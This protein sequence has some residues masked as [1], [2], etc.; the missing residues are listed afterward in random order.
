MNEMSMKS[1]N[2]KNLLQQFEP[3]VITSLEQSPAL[4]VSICFNKNA[5]AVKC[6]NLEFNS[7]VEH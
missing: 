4:V 2:L 5:V 1:R 3:G 7:K 6:A